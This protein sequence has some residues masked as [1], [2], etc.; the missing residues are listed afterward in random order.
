MKLKAILIV[1]TLLSL[2]GC[3]SKIFKYGSVNALPE[4][5]GIVSGPYHLK[6]YEING[7]SDIEDPGCT[8]PFCTKGFQIFLEEGT[9]TIKVEYA[10][11]TLLA[12]PIV[13]E[14][15]IKKGKIYQFENKFEKTGTFSAA[16][17]KPE[18]IEKSSNKSVS[19]I[20]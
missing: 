9:H 2:A 5:V 20:L 19:K 1:V 12:G 10:D 17:W 3:T 14:F 4:N 13:L 7:N 6:L 8:G 15:Q 11:G 16:I 18:I